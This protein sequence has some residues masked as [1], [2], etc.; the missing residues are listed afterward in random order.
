MDRA[1]EISPDDGQGYIASVDVS[2]HPGFIYKAVPNNTGGMEL[3]I[4]NEIY[5]GK[6]VVLAQA[7]NAESL[8]VRV[9]RKFNAAII[10]EQQ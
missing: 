5:A 6:T 10:C 4:E 2:V 1:T 3:S 8:R 7:E 9:D